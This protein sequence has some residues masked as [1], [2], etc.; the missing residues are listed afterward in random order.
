MQAEARNEIVMKGIAASP[1]V[2]HGPAFLFLKK[3]LEIARYFVPPD[4]RE[5]QM[6][7]F[8]GALMETR[9]QISAIRSEIEEK[10]GDEEAQIFDAHQLVLED[11]ALIDETEREIHENGYNI[12]FAFHKVAARYIEAF[13]NI[14]DTYIRERVADIK[15]V[16][17]RLLNN[18]MGKSDMDLRS[19]TGERILVSDELSP[20]DTARLEK[21]RVMAIVTDQGSRTSHAVIM[22]RSINVP[23]VVGLHD[24]SHHVH[25]EDMLIVD[26][27]EGLVIIN[28]SENSLFRYGKIR[29]QRQ[30][31]QRLF[32]ST[33]HLPSITTDGH[34]VKVMLN[35]DG[36][37]SDD[38]LLRSGAAGVGL[39]R[40][41]N[42]FLRGDALP[43]EDE[44]YAVYRH[45]VERVAPFPVTIRTL[46]L[47]GDKTPRGKFLVYD[48]ANPFMGFRAIRLCL[49]HV[50]IFKDQLRA[51]LRASAHGKVK[52][53]YPMICSVRELVAAN[54]LVEECKEEL[55]RKGIPFAAD[56]PVG[57]MIEIPAAAYIADVLARHCQ[58]F[59]IGTNDLIQYVLAVDRVNDRIAH[60][61]EPNH[62][63]IMRTLKVIFDAGARAG[64]PVSVCGEMAGDPAY[65][66]LL[67][68]MGAS[69]L[70]AGSGS[71]AEI[72]YL[73]RNVSFRRARQLADEVLGMEMPEDVALHLHKFYTD[74]I[75]A[76]VAKLTG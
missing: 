26:G 35:V 12:E 6:A 37:E 23:A 36:S 13:S 5:E 74:R 14:D 21:G 55:R 27:Y 1:G 39:F 16:T 9:R 4:K 29:L 34:E 76:H 65:V 60:L 57:S 3:E 64:I 40:T 20:S 44:Q 62:P 43:T 72:K 54:A 32:T 71:L 30:N 70:S 59:S 28:P 25:P 2:A 7:R 52:I 17:R 49:E 47:G 63:A 11:R 45:V 75:G 61:Y 53:M 48:E 10:L 56:I 68:G 73:I 69:E 19:Y 24:V 31:A 41:E 46:D 42:L 51:I 18:L 67:F 58:F 22:A 15:D 8:E 38:T 50:P 66:A 33:V